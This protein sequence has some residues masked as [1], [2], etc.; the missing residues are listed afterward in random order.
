MKFFNLAILTS[1]AFALT[2][3]E[4]LRQAHREE[5]ERDRDL[6]EEDAKVCI[7]N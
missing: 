5:I 6:N 4:Q 1:A 3:R 2:E 7:F